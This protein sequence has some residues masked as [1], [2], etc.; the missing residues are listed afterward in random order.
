MVQGLGVRG[1]EEAP[2]VAG[3]SILIVLRLR[4]AV[5]GIDV[6]LCC[7]QEKERDMSAG[8]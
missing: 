1:E 2:E 6:G 8:R 4:Y 3:S 7:C 5:S